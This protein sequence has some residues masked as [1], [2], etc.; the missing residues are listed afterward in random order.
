MTEAEI[1][2]LTKI[3]D[4]ETYGVSADDV[5]EEM[6]RRATFMPGGGL[7]NLAETEFG[8]VFPRLKKAQDVFEGRIN[9]VADVITRK[10]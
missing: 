4:N 5:D 2:A 8:E 7:M 1:E 6:K 3:V 9:N 10:K